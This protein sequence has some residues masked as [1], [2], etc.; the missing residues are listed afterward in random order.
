ME[1]L[2]RIQSFINR[3]EGSYCHSLNGFTAW[4]HR[5]QKHY[6]L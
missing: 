3:R 5:H 6:I 1:S 2:T 4:I